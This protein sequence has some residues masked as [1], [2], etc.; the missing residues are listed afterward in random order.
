MRE[1]GSD[2]VGVLHW[3]LRRYSLLFLACLILGG[4]VAPYAAK[5]LEKPADAEALVITKRLDMSLTALPRYGEAVFNNGQIEQA[6]SQRFA[7]G[8]AGGNIIPDRVSLVA[9]QDS[10]VFSVVGHD[11]DPKTAA[12]IANTAANTFIEALNVPGL[13]VGQF[14][15]LSSAEPPAGTGSH[16]SRK[17]AIPVGVATGLVLGLA[18]VS[19]LLALRRPVIDGAGVE[20]ATGVPALGVV[21]VPRTRRGRFARPDQFPGLIPVCRRM[22]RLEMPTIV[23]VSQG[24]EQRLRRQLSVALT[25]VL[26]RVRDV[27]F[28]GPDDLRRVVEERQAA[29]DPDAGRS[30]LPATD[31]RWDLTIIDSTDPLELVQPPELTAAVLVAREGVS[32]AALR[33]AVLEHLGGSAKARV[34]LVKRGR[35]ARTARPV[36]PANAQQVE[37]VALAE[38]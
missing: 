23:L 35:R 38:R 13:G 27:R 36:P 21:T 30:G 22:L 15:L 26:M 16:L 12:D 19:L 1:P 29:L 34:V 9:D 37:E 31:G 7:D 6:V 4:V 3:G 25:S 32:S 8:A 18:V 11:P 28:T 24:R 5:K 10:I 2:A 20:E 33:D 17:L 14:G